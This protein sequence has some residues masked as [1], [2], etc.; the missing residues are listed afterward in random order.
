MAK[1]FQGLWMFFLFGVTFWEDENSGSTT[2]SGLES[3]HF[4]IC[5]FQESQI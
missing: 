1:D 2:F 5:G 4:S 3:S